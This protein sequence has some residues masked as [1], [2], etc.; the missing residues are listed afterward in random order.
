MPAKTTSIDLI[1][2]KDLKGNAIP[3]N[4]GALGTLVIV[5]FFWG[6]IA[7]G[8]GIFIPFCKT[9]FNLDQF[10]SQ[11]IDFAFYGAYYIGALVLF[12][13]SAI[14]G[15][16]IMNHW[17]MK[18]GIVYGLIV[19]VVGAVFMLLSFNFGG[20]GAVLASLF[21]IGL[22]FS[23]QQTAANPFA[24]ALGD[25]TTGANR[26][27]LAGGVN[28]FGTTIGPIVVAFALFGH[29]TAKKEDIAAADITSMNFLY[30]GVGIL[31]L[32]AAI[33]FTLSKKLP[34][35]KE[36]D[37]FEGAPKAMWLLIGLTVALGIVFTIIFSS[38]QG[39]GKDEKLPADV[40]VRNMWI[41]VFGL[42]LVVVGLFG[43][44]KSAQKNP[45]GWGAMRFPQ[46]VLGMLAI[47]VY[48]GVEVT[49][50]SNLG[51]L[52]KGPKFGSLSENALAPYISLYWGSMMIGRWTGAISVFNPTVGVKKVLMI[53][54]PY[55]AFGVIIASS[56]IAGHSFGP[57][58][59]YGF[60]ILFQV[61]GF[62]LGKDRPT[63]TL[64]IFGGM[65]TVAM[66]IGLFTTG[67]IA[68]YAFLSGGLFCSIM[69]PSIFTLATAGLGKYTAQGASFLVMMILGG[70]IIPPLQ[71]KLADLESIGIHNSYWIPVLCFAYIIFYAWR[72][73]KV[74]HEQ[75]IDFDKLNSGGG[76]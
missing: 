38:Y 73:K 65:G 4:Y 76:H 54:V 35:V 70:A 28:S 20:F 52:L 60:V 39:L 31:F 58:Y 50:Q 44:N 10:Q 3:T 22:G 18:T 9:Y 37:S 7:A 12:I 34:N 32:A 19:S 11:L 67:T 46:L 33:L 59:M 47:F 13:A 23:L 49:I 64:L 62:F 45:D 63:S 8:N 43:S 36:E 27:N 24:I 68:T 57:L 6:F 66:L 71:G 5:F 48:V 55:V 1:S 29:A 51:E 56:A 72:V 17:G 40:S 61:A 69:W 21:V 53:A 75:G 15:V 42:V 41:L 30:I 74:L 14:R 25:P 16:D 26:L 2:E